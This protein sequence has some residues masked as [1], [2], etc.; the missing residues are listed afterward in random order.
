ME[1]Y[2]RVERPEKG[3][4]G[5]KSW[6]G[7]WDPIIVKDYTSYAM[8]NEIRTIKHVFEQRK[9]ASLLYNDD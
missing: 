6:R 2:I 5:T 8:Y 3:R 9:Y 4:R 1:K 7:R